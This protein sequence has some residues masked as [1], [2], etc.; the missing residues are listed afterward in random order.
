[1]NLNT[2]TRNRSNSLL[3]SR[4]KSPYQPNQ[5]KPN[6]RNSID[7]LKLPQATQDTV[8]SKTDG[9]QRKNQQYTS[10]NG[11]M[12]S[13]SK[14]LSWNGDKDKNML[15]K[16]AD[17]EDLGIFSS[18]LNIAHKTIVKAVDSGEVSGDMGQDA[19]DIKSTG[20][21][22]SF[23]K[24]LD[25]LIQDNDNEDGIS[26]T[27]V[28]FESIR[29]SPINSM[30]NGNL[31]L[32]DF[33]HND[34]QE[35]VEINQD[36][37]DA[38]RKLL[39]VSD[40]ESVFSLQSI[41]LASERR[42]KDFHQIFK[43]LP[44]E[45]H[46]IDDFSCA[47]SKDLLIQ[48]RLYLS[49]NFVCFKSN[50][51]G[52]VTNLLI[53]LQEVV[54]IEKRSTAVLFPN[55]MI[56][57]TLYQ[58]YTFATFV[59]R[60][61]TFK[62]LT[63]VWHRVLLDN[64][65]TIAFE[66]GT[67]DDIPSEAD[68]I[69]DPKE[70]VSEV[71]SE[72]GADLN[73]HDLDAFDDE[74]IGEVEDLTVD[75]VGDDDDLQGKETSD[76]FNGIPVIGPMTHEPTDSG[77]DKNNGDAFIIEDEFKAPMGAIYNI[78]FGKDN[79]YYIKILQNQKNIQID[80]SNI[81][82]I[83]NSNK[84]RNYKYVKPLGG[85]I[86]PKQTA[87]LINDKVLDFDENRRILVEQTTATPDVPSGN[88]FKI[89]TKMYLSWGK[90]NSTKFQ[91]STRIEWLGKS[92]IKGPIEKG[93]IEGQK[94]SMKILIDSVNEFLKWD[95]GNKKKKKTKPIKKS[96]EPIKS[97]SVDK[98]LPSQPEPMGLLDKI[99]DL[100]TTIGS[101][102]PVPFISPTIIGYIIVII[103]LFLVIK[104]YNYIFK[105]QGF[106]LGD[107][108]LIFNNDKYLLVPSIDNRLHNKQTVMENEVN[109]WNWVKDRSG[110]KLYRDD[111]YVRNYKQQE[112]EEMIRLTRLKID[113]FEQ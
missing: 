24:N 49:E 89:C 109:F 19:S 25:N 7:K 48:G 17:N 30:G 27:D 98:V 93:S 2:E 42:N 106:Y 60:D 112:L 54:Q 3:V 69:N 51:L 110:G 99:N 91:V 46:L 75:S 100:I 53:P 79:S 38:H 94:D 108:E 90:N 35:K 44:Q 97:E 96:E 55:G 84:E 43:K 26:A 14:R 4:S 16:S 72:L 10:R 103:Q 92:W 101:N 81:Q 12:A 59:S 70:D 83:L 105:P 85:P 22:S 68:P 1:M 82:G 64:N 107:N 61:V 77:Y 33:A 32:E 71:I 31:T 18:L 87:C 6:S 73:G 58:K 45:E 15:D 88:A 39:I 62:L 113:R 37:K 95:G 34:A 78:L 111:N 28:R 63:N 36:T 8:K 50:I 67:S 104:V 47:L 52:W 102:V 74:K 40:Q 56:I 13:I 23:S 86:G 76:S 5:I 29:E 65:Q 21:S 57:R 80:E 20:K 66:D 41:K 11:S 9:L